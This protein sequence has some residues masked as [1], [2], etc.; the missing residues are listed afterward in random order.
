M[1]LRTRSPSKGRTHE[2][3]VLHEG[4]CRG[5]WTR[6]TDRERV[7]LHLGNVVQVLPSQ[8]L[9]YPRISRKTFSYLLL[10][11]SLLSSRPTHQRILL[12]INRKVDTLKFWY[13]MFLVFQ[14]YVNKDKKFF[15]IDVTYAKKKIVYTEICVKPHLSLKH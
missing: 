7:T 2:G 4:E 11:R 12:D 5:W 10:T 1:T 15:C 3:V 14:T 9:Y 6:L 8:T 13:I